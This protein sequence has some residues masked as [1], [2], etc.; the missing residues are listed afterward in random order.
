MTLRSSTMTETDA[1]ISAPRAKRLRLTRTVIT[2]VTGASIALVGGLAGCTADDP[3]CVGEQSGDVTLTLG[4]DWD[5]PAGGNAG[6][7]SVDLAADPPWVSLVIW[8]ATK[9]QQDSASHLEVNDTFAVAGAT[10]S[11]AGFCEDETYVNEVSGDS[12]WPGAQDRLGV[13]SLTRTCDS[14][15]GTNSGS[16]MS[17]H[18]PSSTR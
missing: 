3:S 1:Q 10:Y 16:T 15:P 5:L 17:S 11:I 13:A 12:S 4:V 9:G 6:I 7:G 18:G 14:G 8:P 2:L